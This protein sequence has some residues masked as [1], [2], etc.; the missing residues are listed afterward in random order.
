MALNRAVRLPEKVF[1]ERSA[2][3]TA[4]AGA[5]LAILPRRAAAERGGRHDQGGE[6]RCDQ[7]L[8]LHVE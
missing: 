7:D 5:V 1:T 4:R 6:G 3:S 8:R 2:Q